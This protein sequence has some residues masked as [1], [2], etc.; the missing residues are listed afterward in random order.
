MGENM[1]RNQKEEGKNNQES[2]QLTLKSVYDFFYK[3]DREK[4]CVFYTDEY[5][6]LPPNIKNARKTQRYFLD[7][8]FGEY[9]VQQ[10]KTGASQYMLGEHLG[11]TSTSYTDTRSD[12][13]HGKSKSCC[14]GQGQKI[15]NKLKNMIVSEYE[16]DQGYSKTVA[17]IEKANAVLL[18]NWNLDVNDVKRKLS[19]F[20]T[21]KPQNLR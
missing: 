3:C 15:R 2:N 9:L 19:I 17:D 20:I 11:I 1:D 10:G 14:G 4:D 12:I 13:M 6:K 16:K 18:L 7:T 8:H 5:E 21:L